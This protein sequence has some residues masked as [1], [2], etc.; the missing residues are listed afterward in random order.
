[1]KVRNLRWGYGKATAEGPMDGDTIVELCV[2]NDRHN[3]FILAV[4]RGHWEDV[5]VTTVPMF[6]IL[7]HIH[8]HD[9]DPGEELA[10]F[11]SCKVESYHYEIGEPAREMANSVFAPAIHLTRAAMQEYYAQSNDDTDALR[12]LEYIRPYLGK[13]FENIKLPKLY[14]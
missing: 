14:A 1:M 4:R 5:T 7:L 8:H 3:Y 11:V 13:K 12:A 6:D 10:K 9:V 2:T